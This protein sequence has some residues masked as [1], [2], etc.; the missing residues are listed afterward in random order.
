MYYDDL[1]IWS[2]L[3]KVEKEGKNDPS[4][5]KYYLFKHLHFTIFYNKDRVIEITAQSDLNADVDLTEEKEVDVEFM[6]SVKWKKTEIP[7]EKRMEKYSQSSSLPHHLEIHWFSI[8]SGVIVLLLNGFFA[9]ILMRVLKNDF[10][11]YAHDEESAEDQEETGW[12]YIHGD[13]FRYPKYKSLLAAAVGSGTQLCT[14]AIFI[15]ML[16]LVGVF[17]PYNR[18]ALLTALVVIYALTAGIA[19]YTAASFFCQLEGTN[20]DNVVGFKFGSWIYWNSQF[21]MRFALRSSEILVLQVRNLLLTGALAL[22]A[23]PLL[24]LG[25]IA[26]KNSK[27][28]FQAPVRTTI[29]PREIPRL[30]WYRK[31]L[32]QMAMAGFLPFSAIYIE[33]YYIFASVWGHRIY[34]LYSFLFIVFIILLIVTAVITVALTYLQLAAEDHEWWWRSFLCGGS[35]GLFI[36]GYCLYY[37]YARSDMSGF[38]QTSFFFGYMA[39]VCYAFFLMLGSIGFRA[40]LLFVRHIYGSIK[41]D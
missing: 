28:E 36:Y 21:E 22:V 6:Y 33:L 16:A 4:E 23:T 11:K 5:Y 38:M 3:G 31:T 9:T 29:Y 37:Y 30:P 35:T 24:V 26:G 18:G 32:P 2:F 40:S 17:Y 10:V 14:L 15:F 27:A 25:G 12:K 7:F 39:C 20:W 41:C 34:I 13:V 19:G 1:P 8:K